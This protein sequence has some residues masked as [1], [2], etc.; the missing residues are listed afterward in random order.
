VKFLTQTNKIM[1]LIIFLWLTLLSNFSFSQTIFKNESL[2]FS[3]EQPS[4]WIKAKE[5]ETT[6][7]L[8]NNIKLDEKVIAKLIEQNK[9]SI[10]VVTFFKY[11]IETTAGIIP[12]IKVNLR[13]N[14]NEN[15][16]DFRKSIEASFSGIKKVFPD[17]KY[18]SAPTETVIDGK[19][20]VTATC[21]YT[22]TGNY[23]KGKVKIIVYA[24][25]VKNQF[26]QITLMDTEEDNNSELFNK[27]IGT[28]SIKE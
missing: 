18:T 12:T 15:F 13:N 21:M 20:C 2:G 28:V 19:K 16:S 5:G 26:Y 22:L 14:P 10:Q 6:E 1:R 11:P 8:K 7:N 3:I 17:F 27:I 23:G 9:G 4:K 24:I 25:P